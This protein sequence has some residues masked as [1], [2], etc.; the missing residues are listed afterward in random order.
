MAL[1]VLRASVVNLSWLLAASIASR[2][3]GGTGE[4]KRP[5]GLP[6]Q[7]FTPGGQWLEWMQV[8]KKQAALPLHRKQPVLRQQQR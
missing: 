7:V 1:R 8:I 4:R 5:A 2:P 3:I 6:H